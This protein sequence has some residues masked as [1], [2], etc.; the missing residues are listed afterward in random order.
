MYFLVARAGSNSSQPN[1][2]LSVERDELGINAGLQDRVIQAYEGL[3]FMDFDKE[4]MS[5]RG[6]GEYTRLDLKNVFS[7]FR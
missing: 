1:L 6:Y 5:S 7:F 2:V 4:L 3:M